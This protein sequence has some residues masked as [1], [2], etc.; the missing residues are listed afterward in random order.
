MTKENTVK[1]IVTKKGTTIGFVDDEKSSVFIA[2]PESN[3]IIF[4]DDQEMIEITDQH[5][6][7]IKMSQKGIEINSA[8]DLKIKASGKIEITGQKVDVK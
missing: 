4:D 7:S 2:T 1:G 8:K 6:N 3:K 5:G